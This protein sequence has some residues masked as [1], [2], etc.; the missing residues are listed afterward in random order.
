MSTELE[1]ALEID[2]KLRALAKERRDLDAEEA[3][4]LAHAAKLP[5][6]RR[7]DDLE[8]LMRSVIWIPRA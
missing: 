3:A 8:S 1:T 7:E 2:R 4:L 5:P 6:R